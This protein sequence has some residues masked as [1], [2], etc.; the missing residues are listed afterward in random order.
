[1]RRKKQAKTCGNAEWVDGDGSSLLDKAGACRLKNLIL[2]KI[3]SF[4]SHQP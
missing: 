4:S 1:V 2:G 3:L